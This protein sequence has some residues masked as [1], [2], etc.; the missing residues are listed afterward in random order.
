MPAVQRFLAQHRNR[1]AEGV[2]AASSVATI[3]DA[4]M[5]RPSA[6]VGS[7]EI[8]LTGTYT[9]HEAAEY[10]IEIVDTTVATPLVT[11]PVFLG[12]GS[13]TLSGIASTGAAQTYTVT[14][15]DLGT[16]LTT[17]G[18]AFEG[19]QLV[20][21]TAGAAGNSIEIT[22]DRSGLTFT[23]QP[24]SLLTA[25]STGAKEVTGPEWDWDTKVM[26]ADGLVPASAH[27]IVFGQDTTNI[28][29]QYKV[30]ENDRWKYRFIPELRD[31]VPAGTQIYF[32]TGGRSVTVTDGA[33]PEV[34]TSVIT[35]YDFLN[36]VKQ[37]SALIDVQGVVANDRA[38]TGQAITEF[39]LRTDAYALRSYGTGSA[40]A[41]GF[42]D[43]EVDASAPT[44]L[45]I[46]KCY[47]NS[48][49]EHPLATIGAERWMV[50]GSVSGALGELVTGELGLF[51]SANF[52]IP[53]KLP[54]GFR[55]S[56]GKF[57]VIAKRF[58]S[59]GPSEETPDVCPVSLELGPN[60]FD[61]TVT[62]TY[63]ARPAGTCTCNDLPA[64]YLRTWCLTGVIDD[65]GPST[66]GYASGT[67]TRLTG[68]YDW[69]RDVIAANSGYSYMYGNLGYNPG[70][71][72]AGAGASQLGVAGW[73]EPFVADLR[74]SLGEFET[75][76]ARVE[77]NTTA[78]TNWDTMIT[79]FKAEIEA[80]LGDDAVASQTGTAT[81][82]E[83]LTAGEFV[84]LVDKGAG[85]KLYKHDSLWPGHPAVPQLFVLAGITSG[86]SGTYYKWG[87]NTALSGLTRGL[88]YIIDVAAPGAVIDDIGTAGRLAL[89]ATELVVPTDAENMPATNALGY[90][91]SVIIDKYRANIQWVLASAGI[92]QAGKSNASVDG[93]GCWHDTGDAFYWTV[94]GSNGGAYAPAFNNM[95][96]YASKEAE[97]GGWYSVREFAFQ[98][99]IGAD[100][101]G[102][103][104]PG[105]EIVLAIGN[106]AWPATYQVGD[107]L[108]LPLVGAQALEL[109]GGVDGTNIQTWYVDGT[110][111]GAMSPYTHN[112]ASPAA[113][114]FGGL[115]FLLEP[116]AIDFAQGD[117]FKFAVEG[118]HYKWRK[119]GGAWSSATVI[120]AG[121]AAL[122][123][124]LS[125][126]FTPGA[127]PAFVTGDTQEF[128]ALQPHAPSLLQVPT[129]AAWQWSG[130][131][132]S[133][134][135]DLGTSRTI[136]ACALA[137]HT[138]PDG[139]TITLEGG[140][141]GVAWLWSES[142]T[143][144]RPI[145]F[146]LFAAHAA[147]YLRLTV[148]SAT[149]GTIGWWW[150]GEAWAPTLSAAV[151]AGQSY[152]VERGQSGTDPA[153]QYLGR[154]ISGEITWSEAALSETDVTELVAMVDAHKAANDA[155]LIII[156]QAERT[157]A[158]LARIV[159]DE[160]Q[161]PDVFDYQPAA[162]RARRLSAT[163]P[164]AGVVN[165]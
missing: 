42:A 23:A 106:A 40:Y 120:P 25:L 71:A 57:S 47:A 131:S 49:K 12:A 117:Q 155:P 130:A 50:E 85:L 58:V 77:T 142:I 3:T 15:A 143:L 16:Q 160:V 128:L 28:Y 35:I 64:P 26:G 46:A 32:V 55:S 48:A 39:K 79:E 6:R 152:R 87:I 162:T 18:V 24:Y 158:W 27:R 96:Y 51:D 147:R 7:A 62:L 90:G 38:P 88:R 154:T 115:T 132:A 76:L 17:A 69:A 125:I 93:D 159:S 11:D 56:R 68:L 113:Y 75:A 14:L 60:A 116:G 41:D 139:A 146:A 133:L 1:I 4:V 34:Y 92:P 86:A 121:A 43:I 148:A 22:V 84:M 103:L 118:G 109:A 119:N 33:T 19:V 150:A 107:Q 123:S 137:F 149:G 98:I 95:P 122:D 156:P 102:L 127:A 91:I 138:L 83:T 29:R 21:R 82:G 157:D 110:V 105:D 67:V 163:L 144:R 10:E 145:A 140:A 70:S 63:T 151:V 100:C 30:Y 61:Q 94:T 101:V 53:Q 80:A 129:R 59:R 126:S 124:G 9:G 111:D 165:A 112:P 45:I 8:A 13:G 52:R 72:G 164:F 44:E 153:A 81:A 73:V 78:E 134:V 2:L 114:S 36:A 20:A 54:V 65:G 66:M 89:S 136:D 97:N 161:L 5:P 37:S 135:A 141:D 104:K 74:R 108:Y 99:N 31:A